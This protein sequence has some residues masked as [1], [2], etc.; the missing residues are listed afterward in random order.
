MTMEAVVTI[1]GSKD[2]KW[3]AIKKEIMD[4]GKFVAKV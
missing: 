3:D 2:I 4:P 1:F